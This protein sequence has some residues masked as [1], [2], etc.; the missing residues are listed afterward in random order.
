MSTRKKLL[1]SYKVTKKKKT[2]RKRK[3]KQI[4]LFT[5]KRN[6]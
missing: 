3:R 2:N 5:R 1:F 4:E 6:Y